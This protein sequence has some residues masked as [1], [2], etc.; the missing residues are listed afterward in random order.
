M[1]PEAAVPPGEIAFESRY[2]A[3]N[4]ARHET[5]SSCRLLN[6]G[7]SVFVVHLRGLGVGEHWRIMRSGMASTAIVMLLVS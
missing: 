7:S 1:H 3:Q 4:S 6:G 2:A 5:K